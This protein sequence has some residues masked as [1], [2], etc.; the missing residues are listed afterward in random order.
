MGQAFAPMMRWLERSIL[1]NADLIL[2]D[3][4]AHIDFYADQ[5]GLSRANLLALP[6]GALEIAET[7]GQAVQPHPQ[8]PFSVLFYGSML[9]LHGIDTIVAAAARLTDLPIRFDFVG[10]SQKQAQNLHQLCRQH[11]IT[12]YTYRRWVPLEDLVKSDIPHADLCLGGPFGGT[13]QARRVVT[14]KT[15][16][17]LALG[18]ATVIRA[19][20]ADLGFIDKHNCLLV[21]Q[22]DPAALA[23]ALRWAYAQRDEL[24]KI[25]ERGRQLYRQKLSVDAIAQ[26]L[27]PALCALHDRRRNRP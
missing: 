13:P 25:G 18:K 9:P 17:A 8:S 24:S 11:G 23:Q 16:Q 15:S 3:T 26:Q 2:T 22:A 14:S 27:C 1:R 20:D 12:H 4:S 7:S 6:V 21:A 5:F 19:T 10:G